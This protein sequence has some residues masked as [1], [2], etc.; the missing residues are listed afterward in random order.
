[1]SFMKPMDG[2]P[3]SPEAR[4]LRLP[5]PP[6]DFVPEGWEPT[7]QQLNPSSEDEEH[8][9][10]RDGPVRV[11]VWDD[12][13]TTIEQARSFR[14]GPTLVLRLTVQDVHDIAQ[15]KKR[16]LGVVY[17]P[18][19]PPDDARLG[20]AGHAGIEGLKRSPGEA[21]LAWRTVLNDLA[22]RAKLVLDSP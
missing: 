3:V 12:A 10:K 20:A 4:I 15:A 5:R 11:S 21:K 17:E 13:L 7:W 19:D 9:R 1:M 16:A 2:Q 18:L 8:A 14:H 6:P 22:G